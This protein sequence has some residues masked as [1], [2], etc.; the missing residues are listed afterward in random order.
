MATLDSQQVGGDH[1]AKYGDLLPWNVYSTWFGDREMRGY[2]LG[3]I[4]KYLVR[5]P[6]K[7]KIKDLL[8]AR[9]VLDKLIE[10]ETAKE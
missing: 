8:K 2:L 4:V 1:Y 5:Y 7:G 10:F 3:S 9:H 6:D